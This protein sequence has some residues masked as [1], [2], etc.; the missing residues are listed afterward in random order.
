M[1]I[2]R[3]IAFILSLVLILSHVNMVVYGAT[4]EGVKYEIAVGV[5]PDDS[6]IDLETFESDLKAEMI[7]EF[8]AAH[9]QNITNDDID[10]NYAISNDIGTAQQA[11]W[12]IYDHYY[13]P[14]YLASPKASQDEADLL[15]LAGRDGQEFYYYKETSRA[16]AGTNY[17]IGSGGSGTTPAYDVEGFYTT[18]EEA[19]D[20]VYDRDKHIYPEGNRITFIGYSNPDYKD[21]MIYEDTNPGDKTIE[22][23]IYLDDVLP[24]TLRGAGFLV[25][26]KITGS[27]PTATIDGY[28]VYYAYTGDVTITGESLNIYK[29]TNVNVDSLHANGVFTG[30]SGVTP[31]ATNIVPAVDG[32]V[33]PVKDIRIKVTDASIKFYEKDGT[34]E[35]DPYKE[36]FSQAINDTNL[37]GFGPFVAYASHNCPRLTIYK[38]DNLIMSSSVTKTFE[39]KILEPKWHDGAVHALININDSGIVNYTDDNARTEMIHRLVDRDV[40][41][42]GWGA[43]DKDEELSFIHDNNDLGMY[44]DT[45]V[46]VNNVTFSDARTASATDYAAQVTEI[47]KYLV[48]M[49]DYD[50]NQTPVA[51]INYDGANLSSGSTDPNGDVLTETW[52]I[53]E[54]DDANWTPATD[55][56]DATAKLDT[57]L[58]A[59]PEK[60]VLVQLKVEDTGGNISESDILYLSTEVS[61][62]PMA[63]FSISEAIDLETAPSTV[64]VPDNLT[65][66]PLVPSRN[67]LTYRWEVYDQMNVLKLSSTAFEPSLDFAGLPAGRYD[68]KLTV[69]AA[70]NSIHSNTF[71]Q[72]L[73]IIDTVAPTLLVGLTGNSGAATATIE[74]IDYGSGPNSYRVITKNQADVVI[75]GPWIPA[76]AARSII[77]TYDFVPTDLKELSFEIKDGSG[78]TAI[79]PV[80]FGAPMIAFTPNGGDIY[81]NFTYEEDV[82]VDVSSLSAATI[83]DWYYEWLTTDTY[84][85][86]KD[87]TMDGVHVPDDTF[88]YISQP[89]EIGNY[90]LHIMAINSTLTTQT[91][92][93]ELFSVTVAPHGVH[94]LK[95]SDL[96]GTDIH[97]SWSR[98]TDATSQKIQYSDNDG[99]TWNDATHA[100]LT[101]SSTTAVVTGMDIAA[102]YT[103]KLLVDGGDDAGQSNI[104]YWYDLLTYGG[105]DSNVSVTENLTLRTSLHQG[106]TVTWATTDGTIAD[107]IGNIYRPSYF[108]GNQAATLTA[109]VVDGGASYDV[110]F[111]LTVIALSA[112][113]VEAVAA[114][115]AALAIVYGGADSASSVTANVTLPNVTTPSKGS[116]VSWATSD[117]GVISIGGITGTVIRPAFGTGDQTIDL[118]A[119][120]NK[121]AETETRI[122]SVIVKQLP[123][124][125]AA[126]IGNVEVVYASLDSV[127]NVTQDVT[128]PTVATNGGTVSWVSDTP[129]TIAVNGTVTRP[130]NTS[131]DVVVRL[132]ATLNAETKIFDLTVKEEVVD[133]TAAVAADKV[134]LDIIYGAGDSVASVTQD[135]TLLTTLTNDS[136]VSWASDDDAV[137][138][139]D[140][141]VIRPANG[142]GD[143]SIT[144]TATI[145]KGVE[146]DTKVFNLTVKETPVDQDSI[147]TQADHTAL[148]IVY[149]AGDSASYVTQNIGL[150]LS[151]VDG[152]TITWQSSSDSRI[153]T[154]GNVYRPHSSVGDQEVT[155]TATIQKGAS[156]RTKVFILTVKALGATNE[157]IL[158][159]D[160]D[161]L[162][163][164]YT[165]GDSA[166][167]VTQRLTLPATGTNGSTVTWSSDTVGN[168]SADG[169]VTRP[170][171]GSPDKVV[172]LTATLAYGGDEETRIYE[173][174][175]KAV[176]TKP[177]RPSEPTIKIAT[178]GTIVLV[179]G[180]PEVAG[181]ETAKEENGKKTV[182]VTIN[183]DLISKKMKEVLNGEN[184]D[185]VNI[186]SIPV[187]ATDVDELSIALTGDIV[188]EMEDSDFDISIKAETIEY[189]I[190]A[191]EIQIDNV[192]KLLGVDSKD[193]KSIKINIEMN[194]VNDSQVAKII[195][196]AA[197]NSYQVVFP[198]CEFKVEA[199]T[200]SNSSVVETVT[201]DEFSQYVTRVVQLPDGVDPDKITTGIVYNDDG[202]FAHIPTV[203]FQRDGNYFAKLNSMTNSSYSVIW[204]PTT[205][206]SVQDHWSKTYV[207][208]MASRLIIKNPLTF[209]PDKPIGRGE[210]AEYLVKAIGLYRTEVAKEGIFTD[211]DV[212]DELADALTIANEYGIVIGYEDGT[213][214]ADDIITREEAM[215]MFSRTMAIIK[216]NVVIDDS[217]ISLYEDEPMVSNWA[218]GYVEQS[219][220]SGVFNGRT[221][222]TIVPK[223]ILTY[224]E[225]ATAVSNLLKQAEL[226]N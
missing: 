205:V 196:D 189:I 81:T 171:Y 170:S 76:I 132:T 119:T 118:T 24:H 64:V 2:K 110:A 195:A 134:D 54:A 59:T 41:Y 12:S 99:M 137:V 100:A 65:F 199:T 42:I 109:T 155:L 55:A 129:G 32:R 9:G 60:N 86:G 218:Y 212:T 84:P 160:K 79:N 87:I 173:V 203:V 141:T 31:V 36:A 186:V 97:L 154:I 140:G 82:R 17:A 33:I 117:N 187:S 159:Y 136:T 91:A 183:N 193:L 26:S 194:Q 202:T 209:E 57:Y 150:A 143:A 49:L 142:D 133:D 45:T 223:G 167:S 115:K 3:L 174:I 88:D 44:I 20:Y 90:Y 123:E 206:A 29:L 157:S 50:I 226:I 43:G 83:D 190:P 151:G 8:N 72:S 149:G 89:A 7:S 168:I 139:T 192:S 63:E 120:I 124:T 21:F 179:N 37:D 161:G 169:S 210:F 27:G 182:N 77:K 51:I 216:F 188:K 122:F 147:D 197:S 131:G 69:S 128:L 126:S 111:P 146:S 125:D 28:L 215:T 191:E 103:F 23:S 66:D 219:I 127:N 48:G 116:T 163:I 185:E 30:I 121:G 208:D 11:Q 34:L 224:A 92:V 46:G 130:A 220:N 178:I 221:S 213:V 67:D 164:G 40:H 53:K 98:P 47:A 162:A 58:L 181:K 176:S 96:N 177:S 172:R 5:D 180:V 156:T 114:D 166:S 52:I 152:S 214:G 222:T 148:G 1:K 62:K 102:D 225:A 138:A 207:D 112:T 18:P 93:S 78:N 108:V 61:V 104:A 25:N 158:T 14:T 153:D 10:I 56:A 16:S 6:A 75:T 113:D 106:A 198:P 211:L 70:G 13:S 68:V 200:T 184:P 101:G 35:N 201:M 39:E 105:V 145:S 73:N 74:I 38:Y 19:T 94:D 15:T 85:V 107:I 4:T 144:V 204:N 95:V 22:Y 165:A 135:I 217:R 175:V 80:D 71:V